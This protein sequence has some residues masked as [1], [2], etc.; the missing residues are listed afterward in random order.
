M[1][2][3][4]TG[5]TGFIGAAVCQKL[6]DSRCHCVYAGIRN[7][8][9]EDLISRLRTE[10]LVLGDLGDSEAVE[11]SLNHVDVVIHTAALVHQRRRKENREDVLRNYRKINVEG[12]LSLARN[13]SKCGVKRFVFLS[14]I[15]VN[16]E[17]TVS[18][19]EFHEEDKPSPS[20]AYAISKMEAEIGL[21]MLSQQ[22]GMEV[23]IIRPP[24]VYGP[25]VKANFRSMIGWVNRT[26]PLP[27]GNIGN[28]RSL[29]GIDNLVDF[30]HV[31]V[32]HPAAANRT[33]LVSDGEDV[34]TTELLKRTAKS[35]GK[36]IYLVPIHPR[37]LLF[38]GRLLGKEDVVQKLTSSLRVD[39]SKSME[40][41]NWTPPVSLDDGLKITTDWFNES[42]RKCH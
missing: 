30:I 27:L 33:F 1:K 18:G 16:G 41:L 4:V 15:K 29:V 38:L 26:V 9:K 13:A 2:V 42:S 19:Q 36:S 31:C 21:K 34:S 32:E 3:L 20:G 24:L 17:S 25:D 8:D 5:A 39:I 22:T 6:K 7:A 14:T 12:T 37:V 10:I 11:C 35:M 23:V 40:L 28:K